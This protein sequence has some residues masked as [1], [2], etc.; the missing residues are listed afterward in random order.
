MCILTKEGQVIQRLNLK[1]VQFKPAVA[2]G[3]Y[4]NLGFWRRHLKPTELS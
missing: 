2:R 4:L 1:L 3:K